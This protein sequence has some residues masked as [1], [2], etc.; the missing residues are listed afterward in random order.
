MR[1]GFDGG[2]K[3]FDLTAGVPA[4]EE[5]PA[6]DPEELLEPEDDEREPGPIIRCAS[7]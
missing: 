4:T 2:G 3:E 6:E 1:F 5:P 7:R